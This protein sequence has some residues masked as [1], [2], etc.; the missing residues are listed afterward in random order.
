MATKPIGFFQEDNGNR[1]MV[2]LITFIG[3]MVAIGFGVRASMKTADQAGSDLQLTVIF[4]TA[5]VTG[6]VGQKFAEKKDDLDTFPI[7]ITTNPRYA[8]P[9]NEP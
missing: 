7:A 9:G 3:F 2:R 4:L 5:S 8:N 1:S 6:K